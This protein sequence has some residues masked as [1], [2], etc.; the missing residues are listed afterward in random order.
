MRTEPRRMRSIEC[1]PDYF[2]TSRDSEAA[3]L[4]DTAAMP[5]RGTATLAILIEVADGFFS[6]TVAP[7]LLVPRASSAIYAEPCL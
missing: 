1:G 2:I 4:S 5:K 6:G 7:H 3:W